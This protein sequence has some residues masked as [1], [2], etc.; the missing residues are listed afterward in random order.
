[1]K[2]K[3]GLI[4]AAARKASGMTQA[5]MAK[6]LGIS[7]VSVSKWENGKVSL[8]LDNIQRWYSALNAEGQQMM[9]SLNFYAMTH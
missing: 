9:Q 1:M 7:V 6:A 4:L 2:D 5:D 3:T 8:K